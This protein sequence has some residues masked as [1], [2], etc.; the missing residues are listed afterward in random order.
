MYSAETHS[1]ED[2]EASQH[3]KHTTEMILLVGAVGVTVV[4]FFPQLPFWRRVAVDHTPSSTA[5][6]KILLPEAES[7]FPSS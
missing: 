5:M 1:A 7:T 3:I 4:A 6:T 2:L